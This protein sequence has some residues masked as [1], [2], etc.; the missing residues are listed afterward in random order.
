MDYENEIWKDIV[1]EKNGIIYDYTGLYKVSNYG[2][3]MSYDRIDSKGKKQKGIMMKIILNKNGY[4]TVGLSKCGKTKIF[5]VHR[6]V[7]TAFIK[8]DNPL[9]KTEVNH[10]DFNKMNNRVD[11]LEWCTRSENINH[12][13]NSNEEKGEKYRNKIKEQR[14]GKPMY[15]I[16]VRCVET[17]QIFNSIKE[18]SEWCGVGRSHIGSCCKGKRKTCGGYHW[19]YA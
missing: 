4:T 14:Q 16:K 6:L 17:G 3:V 7:A 5:R 9:E 15:T 2:R 12:S 19:E 1:I 10:I 11:N 8:N 18:A 13:Y